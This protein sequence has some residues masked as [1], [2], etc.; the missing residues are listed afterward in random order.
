LCPTRRLKGRD[1]II[2]GEEVGPLGEQLLDLILVKRYVQTRAHESQR[3]SLNVGSAYSRSRDA[4]AHA[5][6]VAAIEP[7]VTDVLLAGM[8]RLLLV[9]AR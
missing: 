7:V 1:T 2:G 3:D 9:R 5:R 4:E 6:R 8:R